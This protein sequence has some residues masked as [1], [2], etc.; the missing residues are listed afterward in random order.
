MKF[1][2]MN[3]KP[4]FV[5]ALKKQEIT[6]PTPIQEETIPALLEGKDII[7]QAKTGSGKTLAFG[8]PLIEACDASEKL[9]QALVLAPTR[10]LAQQ[11]GK[12]I[13]ELAAPAGLSTVILFGGVGYGPQD[14]ALV[15][16]PQIVVGTPGR[17]L[18]HLRRGTLK[19]AA[20]HYL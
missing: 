9:A 4:H 18:D 2:E 5:E 16:G 6:E 1:I 15:R 7:A 14:S 8:L 12:V 19:L 3:L 13:G 11:V 17:I 10:E 20:V